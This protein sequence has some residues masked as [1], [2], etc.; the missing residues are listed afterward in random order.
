MGNEQVHLQKP[1]LQER[2]RKRWLA[3]TATLLATS[4]L[5][6]GCF[7]KSDKELLKEQVASQ[8]RIIADLN[9]Q[10]EAGSQQFEAS[11]MTIEAT[12]Q[13]EFVTI[14]NK[15]NFSTDVGM[16]LTTD[17]VNNTNVRVGS[18]FTFTP[19]N[20]WT[21][22]VD[23]STV[24]FEHSSKVWG[25]IK[26]LKS[27]DIVDKPTSEEMKTNITNFFA[28]HA[29]KNTK[30]RKL[31]MADRLV[32]YLGEGEIIVDKKKY[33]LVSGLYLYGEYGG[34]VLFTYEDN[35]TGVQQELIDLLLS[36]GRYNETAL[37][38]D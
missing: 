38:I 14:K 37:I 4:V 8:E 12:G 20:N 16:S 23:G 31:Y 17:D 2:T 5:L 19:Y 10:L 22:K 28:T 26:A 27:T 7:G 18:A 6:T 32:G 21:V 34:V 35:Q 25:S 13:Q 3:L 29:V 36:S 33:V 1:Q 9:K 30:F 24:N 11:L 15:L